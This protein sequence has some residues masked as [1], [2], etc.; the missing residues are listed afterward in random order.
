MEVVEG[1]GDFVGG[2]KAT[3]ALNNRENQGF[4]IENYRVVKEC[5][6]ESVLYIY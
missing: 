1:G 2:V 5:S 4:I 3:G 6:T